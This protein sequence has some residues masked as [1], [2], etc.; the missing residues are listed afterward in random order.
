MQLKFI[1]NSLLISLVL[2]C[3]L[4]YA[5]ASKAIIYKKINSGIHW[6]NFKRTFSKT[7]LNSSHEAQKYT[8][9]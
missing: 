4:G 8:R 9:F 1:S 2:L 5:H 3:A 7:Y 6:K